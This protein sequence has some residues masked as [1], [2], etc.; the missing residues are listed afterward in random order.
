M[1]PNFA[2]TKQPRKLKFQIMEISNE[3]EEVPVSELISFFFRL[4]ERY[5]LFSP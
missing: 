5:T 1:V 3:L 2:V 4:V